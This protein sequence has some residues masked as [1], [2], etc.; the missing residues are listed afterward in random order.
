MRLY[1]VNT[2]LNVLHLQVVHLLG[3]E[4]LVQIVLPHF[5]LLFDDQFKE[6]SLLIHMANGVVE[7]KGIVSGQLDRVPVEVVGLLV[8]R[9][10]DPLV[11]IGQIEIDVQISVATVN[12][13]EGE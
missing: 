1:G 11:R 7:T 5:S 3:P 9:K 12:D 6:D 2:I 13:L 8:V 10:E 4:T